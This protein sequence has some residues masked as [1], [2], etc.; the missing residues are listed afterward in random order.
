MMELGTWKAISLTRDQTRLVPLKGHQFSASA[1][2][3]P[4][5]HG[6]GG[7]IMPTGCVQISEIAEVQVS[8][9]ATG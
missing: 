8:W 1:P 9:K 5:L 6:L 3:E 2:S 4:V 7:G